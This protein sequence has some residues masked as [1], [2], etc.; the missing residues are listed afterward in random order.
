M[1]GICYC[2][3]WFLGHP[4]ERVREWEWDQ[5]IR[6]SHS[7]SKHSERIYIY[8]CEH[9]SELEP[10]E[11]VLWNS[12]TLFICQFHSLLYF[13]S[14]L[15]LDVVID[16]DQ[17]MVEKHQGCLSSG[18]YDYRREFIP[19]LWLNFICDICVLHL[20]C[21]LLEAE[22]SCHFTVTHLYSMWLWCA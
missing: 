2:F 3:G 18:A 21:V 5:T 20:I 10:H 17:N 16:K 6:I 22:A 12:L 13:Y 14:F 15:F 8:C 1:N 19:I 9:A 4:S 7:Y 11:V